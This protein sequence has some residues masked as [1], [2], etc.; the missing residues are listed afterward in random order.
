MPAKTGNSGKPCRYTRLADG[1][2]VRMIITVEE[3]VADLKVLRQRR[4]LD[5]PDLS[6]RISD[7]VRA[8]FNL[9]GDQ[10]AVRERLAQRLR[11]LAE[12]L[13][14]DLGQAVLIAYGLTGGSRTRLLNDR[15]A[16]LADQIDRD[17]RTAVR[18]IDEGLTR[19][20]QAALAQRRHGP[21]DLPGELP[22]WRT[23]TLRTSVVLDRETPEVYEI[24]RIAAT[25]PA[26]TEIELEFSI[27]IPPDWTG[28][29]PDNPRIDVLHGGTLHTRLWH[30]RTRMGYALHLPRA[31]T[32]DEEHEFF[33]RFAFADD[34]TMSRFYSCTPKFPCALFELHVRFGPD[35]VPDH[36]WKINGLLPTEVDDHLAPREP[37]RADAASEAHLVFTNLT[38]N[39][40]F[41]AAWSA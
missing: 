36:L 17:V 27:P 10:A 6:A 4:A 20:A 18:R 21:D 34:H 7:R 16:L 33:L 23:T 14:E 1:E 2:E 19:I 25:I 15:V 8:V 26:L 3:L 32:Q 5:A 37:I 11:E 40:S 12:P 35:R 22:P 9:D 13:P 29:T 28:N 24:R 31:L 30:S 41:G 38:P 39:L